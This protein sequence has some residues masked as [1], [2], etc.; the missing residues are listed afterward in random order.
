M[1]MLTC[2]PEKDGRRTSTKS[3]PNLSDLLEKI[4]HQP[5]TRVHLGALYRVRFLNVAYIVAYILMSLP[6]CTLGCT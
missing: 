1:I 5:M 4:H 3:N 2:H 6:G